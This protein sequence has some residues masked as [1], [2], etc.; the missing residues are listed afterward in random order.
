MGAWAGGCG[1]FRDDAGVGA[2]A[3][4]SVG[5]DGAG[6]GGACEGVGGCVC[7]VGWREDAAESV[8]GWGDVSFEST[9]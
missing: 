6:G 9:L 1:E 4:G 8:V 7:T 3:V 5:A 2:G